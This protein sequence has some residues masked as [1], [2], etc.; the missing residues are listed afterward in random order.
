MSSSIGSSG[1][2]GLLGLGDTDCAMAGGRCCRRCC[3]RY[4][5]LLAENPSSRGARLA[6]KTVE[7]TK[8]SRDDQQHVAWTTFWRH[9]H[10]RHCLPLPNYVKQPHPHFTP[11]Y[12]YLDNTQ[13]TTTTIMDPEDGDGDLG[14]AFGLGSVLAEAGVDQAALNAFLERTEG[15]DSR[16]MA[17]VAETAGEGKF[18]DDV[19]EGSLP[20]ENDEDRMSRAREQAAI[21]ANEE[22]WARRA[23]AELSGEAA[24]ERKRKQRRREGAKKE[25]VVETVWPDYAPGTVLKMTEVFYETPAARKSRDAALVAKKRKLL[26]G[27][28][29]EQ[30]EDGVV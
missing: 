26:A 2:L 19:S 7:K 11:A 4:K 10:Y 21:K 17:A 27:P 6:V 1:A 18:M 16:E 8:M 13:T 15:R 14:S 9:Q 28:A 12:K 23:A 22:R 25:K 29:R 3:D 20:D 24:T 5:V 30:C